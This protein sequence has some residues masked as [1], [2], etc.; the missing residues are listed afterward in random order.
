MKMTIKNMAKELYFK[1][2][3]LLIPNISPLKKSKKTLLIVKLDAIGDY[4]LFRNFLKEIRT[5]LLYKD[6]KITLLGNIINKE[7]SETLDKKFID[8][9]VW[10]NKKKLLKNPL[11]LLKIRRIIGA[12]FEK[13]IHASYSREFIGDLLVNFS[14][15]EE[16]IGF[17]GDCNN[18]SMGVKKITD[19][20]YTK[21]I[22]IDQDINFEFYRNRCFFNK[23][24]N[25]ISPLKKPDIDLKSLNIIP[26]VGLPSTYVVFFPGGSL[27]SKR[28][29]VENFK[30]IGKYLINKYNLNVIIC[31]SNGD[32]NLAKV[33]CSNDTK[34]NDLTGKTTLPQLI[35]VISK[36]K[37]VISNDTGGAH[38]A[39]ALNIPVIV[40]SRYNHYMRFV[41][42][43]EEISN[44]FICLLPNMFNDLSQNDLV[45]KFK[46]NSNEDISLITVNS[47]ESVVDKVYSQT[48]IDLQ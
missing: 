20:W 10:I 19:T 15:A 28:W 6:Y 2:V 32:Q 37:F 27:N 23:V 16:R 7:L 44:N 36:A 1:F 18:I 25:N 24:L 5:S 40:M 47:V 45:K 38:I 21:L 39:A 3:C 11:S 26:M 34:I 48:N 30:L 31:G 43:P 33:I 41:P 46:N 9:F 17:K 35:H 14:G 22:G 12:R 13:T 8:D 4:I 29:P 42:Y